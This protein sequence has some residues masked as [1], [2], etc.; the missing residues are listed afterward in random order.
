M[1]C[2][3]WN[4]RNKISIPVLLF[5]N[6]SFSFSKSPFFPAFPAWLISLDWTIWNATEG[7]WC[8][9]A[10]GMWLWSLF[11]KTL[12]YNTTAPYHSMDLCTVNMLY[13][14]RVIIIIKQHHYNKD[15][16]LFSLDNHII[17]TFLSSLIKRCN[18]CWNL[19]KGQA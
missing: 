11:S 10:T 16:A 15:S 5:F 7:G 18:G 3:N 9:K 8:D 14:V 2:Y 4:T 1:F 12:H 6:H 19:F 13:C 17:V